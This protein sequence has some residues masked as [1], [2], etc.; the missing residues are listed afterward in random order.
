MATEKLQIILDAAWR[1]KSSIQQANKDITKLDGG[2]G[3]AK[4]N[5]A[6]FAV[7]D[8]CPDSCKARLR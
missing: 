1:G 5:L 3:K 2:V 6:K 8:E 4:I 7:A